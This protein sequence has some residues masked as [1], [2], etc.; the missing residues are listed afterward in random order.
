MRNSLHLRNPFGGGKENNCIFHGNTHIVHCCLIIPHRVSYFD[1]MSHT[2]SSGY[3]HR[4][5]LLCFNCF[6]HFS[7]LSK[8]TLTSIARRRYE[9]QNLILRQ[10]DKT[11]GKLERPTNCCIVPPEPYQLLFHP[12]AGGE[13]ESACLLQ[14]WRK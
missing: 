11:H 8:G 4:L 3:M 5:I 1:V 9:S 14:K 2:F 10:N 13:L 12:I 7:S 6:M